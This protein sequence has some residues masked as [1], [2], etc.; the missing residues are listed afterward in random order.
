MK[1]IIVLIVILSI[2]IPV[3]AE[4]KKSASSDESGSYRLGPLNID[5][6]GDLRSR[7]AW[8]S[9]PD[10]D[11]GT[12]DS[13]G[14]LDMRGRLKMNVSGD[15]PFYFRTLLQL[16]D[17]E[18]SDDSLELGDFTNLEMK[19]LYLGFKGSRLK[20]KVGIIDLN[21]PGSYV[22]DSDELGIQVKYDFFDI[23]T[24]RAF[25]SAEDLTDGSNESPQPGEYMD[26]LLFMGLEQDHLLDLDLWTMYYHGATQDF[27]FN[28][29]WIGVEG[30]KKFNKLK[31]EAGYTYNFG[32]VES[33]L[34]PLSAYFSH[35]ELKYRTDK[36]KSFFTRFN[37]TSGC[38]GYLDSTGQFQTLDGEGNLET[39]LGLLFG[40]SPYDSMAY[41]DNECLSIVEDNLNDGEISF[42]DPGLFVYEFGFSY[43]F[44]SLIDLD[45]ESVIVI[46][47]ANTG[48]LFEGGYFYSLIA[49]E[50]DIHNRIEFSDNLEFA[51]SLAYLVP[52]NSFNAVYEL[53]H[54]DE[55]L[56]L[57][58]SSFKADCQLKYSF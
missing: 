52:G 8:L 19:E 1:R 49:W 40:G 44:G 37:L 22:Y 26:H 16:G 25:Y 39:D 35:L 11:Y 29:W 46:G 34:I 45:L 5:L 53:N 30:K 14:A 7:M 31:V 55:M 6:G 50:A 28:S 3:F 33:Y 48:D 57:E 13:E 12:S 10:L 18:L 9:N 20:L 58:S 21:T 36:S 51:L 23:V 17:L 24:A 32:E 27:L 38:D 15:S 41:Y 2:T 42:Y 43:D 54:D 56:N 47:G 4:S